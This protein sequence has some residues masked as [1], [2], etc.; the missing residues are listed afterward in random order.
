MRAVNEDNRYL[1]R[2]HAYFGL[3]WNFA[4]HL[5]RPPDAGDEEPAQFGTLQASKPSL[6]DHTIPRVGYTPGSGLPVFGQRALS[7]SR[8]TVL[9]AE[10]VPCRRAQKRSFAP[11]FGLVTFELPGTVAQIR[12]CFRG[13]QPAPHT[14]TSRFS[15]PQTR[16]TAVNRANSRS[17]KDFDSAIVWELYLLHFR[18]AISRPARL[19]VTWVRHP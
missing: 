4:P 1:K 3:L 6:S 9:P 16:F 11:A 2:L 7:S 19:Q 14:V 18:S 10:P 5:D 17:R 13:P 8:S 12:Q 15:L